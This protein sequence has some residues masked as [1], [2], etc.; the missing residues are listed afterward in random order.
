MAE[1]SH[2]PHPAPRYLTHTAPR[3][4]ID[5]AA[6]SLTDT[7]RLRPAE[8]VR[9]EAAALEQLAHRLDGSMR[10]PFAAVVALLTGA[11]SANHRVIVTGVGKSGI[12]AQK[13]AAT[14]RSTGTPAHFL[15]PAEALHGDLGMVLPGDPV[16]MLSASGE[17]AELL[18]LLPLL[19]RMETPL[20]ALCG[21]PTSTLAREAAH[22][23]DAT[24][25]AEACPHNLAPTASTTVLLALGDALALSVSQ[26]RGFAPEDFA[27]LHPGGR[28]GRRLARVR[29]L[30]HTGDA[31]PTVSPDC[32]LPELIHEM[33]RKKLGVTLVVDGDRLLGIISDGDLRRLLE[34]D[35]ADALH[36]HAGEIL[37]PDP[38]TISPDRFAT[39]A[40]ALLE[41]RK[42]TSLVAVSPTGSPLGVLHM[43]DL[44]EH[45]P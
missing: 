2:Q 28:L 30:M 25:S 19:A 15:H 42:I 23:L 17:T 4:S 11:A 10:E 36:R 8:L 38:A 40:L 29:D 41:E 27:T 5:P 22:V 1:S 21:C 43:H 9:A 3:S 32:S 20:V 31:M 13:L 12:I 18:A 37:H 35:G 44:W 34:R 26:Q 6:R 24:I 7:A 16:L 14:L 33:S 45:Q 39:E